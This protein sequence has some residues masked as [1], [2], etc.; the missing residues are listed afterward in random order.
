MS[1]LSIAPYFSFRQI[2]ITGQTVSPDASGA[3]IHAEPD[4]R[5]QPICQGCGEKASGTYSWTQ[6][7]IRGL[8]F[9]TAQTWITCRYRKVFYAHC[10]GI[11]IE[12]L[13]L[14][15]SYLRVTNRL[16]LYI[17]ELCSYMTISQVSQHL[18]I[19]WKTVKNIDKLYLEH[20]YGNPI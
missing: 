7:K 9:G 3:H 5:F 14:F 20:D 2:K 10:Q 17:C 12:D 19:D 15:H 11:H 13:E 6:R 8:C 1:T 18:G 16:A 4:K